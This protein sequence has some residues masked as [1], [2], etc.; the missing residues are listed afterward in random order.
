VLSGLRTAHLVTLPGL[1]ATTK[2]YLYTVRPGD[3]VWSIASRIDPSG[4]P[5]P[6]VDAIEARLDEKPI[7]PGERV[8]VP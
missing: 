6:L 3:T 5:R 1:Q 2:G 4:D 7:V 8:V